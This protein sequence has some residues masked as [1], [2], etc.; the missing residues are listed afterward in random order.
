MSRPDEVLQY[1]S[2][3]G[4]DA[5]KAL[6][7]TLNSAGDDLRHE[8]INA[9]HGRYNLDRPYVAQRVFVR[10][11]SN[12]N[13]LSVTISARVRGT[14]LVRF[15]AQQ[16]TRP[17]KTVA[18]RNAGISVNVVRAN[19][20]ATLQQAFFIKLKRGDAETG[21]FG[22]A[23]RVSKESREYEIK[24]SVSVH[25]AFNWFRDSLEPSHDQLFEDFVS[26]LT[27]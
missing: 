3:L 8:A 21:N 11:R 5:Q 12:P 6:S 7:D 23:Q 15:G 27:L 9:I 17:G 18:E 13:N 4:S 2:R 24:Y 20:R 10:T 16:V 25:Q 22:I 1:L 26:R 19:A 14:Q